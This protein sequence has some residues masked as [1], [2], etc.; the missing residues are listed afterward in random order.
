MKQAKTKI[1][2]VII[3]L[4]L[5]GV[6]IWKIDLGNVLHVFL[7]A[8]WPYL[9]PALIFSVLQFIISA[10]AGKYL[11]GSVSTI[12]LLQL[13]RVNFSTRFLSHITPSRLSGL[14]GKPL[15]LSRVMENRLTI[16]DGGVFT[17]FTNLVNSSRILMLGGIGLG[18]FFW[19]FNP[20]YR[21]AIG[22]SLLVYFVLCLFSIILI[23][24]KDS[25]RYVK[26]FG[27]W[28]MNY[29]PEFSVI[30]D[31]SLKFKNILEEVENS[32]VRITKD[33]K[34]FA[35]YWPIIW[36]STTFLSAFRFWFLFQAFSRD[37]NLSIL[38]V[39][40]ILAYSVTVLPLSVGGMGAAEISGVYAFVVIGV[41]EEIAFSVILLDRVLSM[42]LIAMVG[43]FTISSFDLE[44]DSQKD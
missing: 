36:V 29:L 5:F 9:F 22:G 41:E 12:K 32:K 16:E 13:L 1:L 38:F 11:I 10:V 43:A 2:R 30:E 6:I 35:L 20:A 23:F 24:R 40:P 15:L 28:C 8:R 17:V 44:R 14:A 26:S 31:L 42:Y 18:I 34:R 39:L 33:K 21:I 7:Q 37:L 3:G 4:G 19:L 27:H 25:I